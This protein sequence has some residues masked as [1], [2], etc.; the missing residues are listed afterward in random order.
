MT[1]NEKVPPALT[2][3]LTSN[4][5]DPASAFGYTVDTV[6]PS[7]GSFFAERSFSVQGTLLTLLNLTVPGRARPSR[8]RVTFAPLTVSPAPGAATL[9]FRYVTIV[10]PLRRPATRDPDVPKL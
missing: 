3:E 5:T 6:L 4:V 9:N 1:A 2:T 10:S 7:D 8:V